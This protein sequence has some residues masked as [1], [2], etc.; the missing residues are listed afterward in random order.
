MQGLATDP[1]LSGPM[2]R[3]LKHTVGPFLNIP[4]SMLHEENIM[5]LINEPEASA[6]LRDAE[7]SSRTGLK[8][9]LRGVNLWGQVHGAKRKQQLNRVK[10]SFE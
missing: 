3:G 5:L 6:Q 10:T 8:V 9:L 2:V 1:N 4:T 7:Q